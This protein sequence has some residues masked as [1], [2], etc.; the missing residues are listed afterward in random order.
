MKKNEA[1]RVKYLAYVMALP[2]VLLFSCSGKEETRGDEEE[3]AVQEVHQ[4]SRRKIDPSAIVLPAGMKIEAVAE[5]LSYPVDVT[6]DDKGNTYIAEAGGHTYGTKPDRAPEARIL[7]LLPD[8]TT[9]VLYD[10]VVP[11]NIIKN[12]ASSED[13]EEGLIPPLTGVTYH[14][15][16]LYISHRSRYSTYDLESG[17]FETIINGLPSW[18]EF[19]N[20]KPIFKD[21]KMY[22]FLSTQGNTGVQEKHWVE[23][24]NDFN[25]PE[26]REIPGED[27]TLTGKNFWVPTDK[28][29]IVDADSLETGVYVKLGEKTKAGQV[30]KGQE[31]C[32]GAFFSC[33]LDGNNIKRIAWGLRSS[34][35][36]RFSPDGKLITTMNSANPMPPRGLYFD[37]EPVYE[38]V[39]G[40]WYGW[41]DFFSGIPITDE[42]FS[43][44]EKR[45]DFVLT[46]ETHRKLLK[47]KDK[48]RQPIALLPVHSAAQGMVFG[49]SAFG[50][51]EQD[52]LVA[53][54]G[55]IVPEF[56]GKEYHPKLPKGMPEEE[57]APTGVKYNWPG[58]K[59]QQV[60][61]KTG[62]AKDFIYNKNSLP[63]SVKNTGGLERPLQME[64]GKDGALY[65]VDFGVVEFDDTGMNAMPFT[66]VLWKV[67]KGE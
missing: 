52:I 65:I 45:W 50:V 28:M 38:I 36:Y 8:G 16:K 55:T 61:L 46:E 32:N 29:T 47:G 64:W 12:K 39:Q 2:A 1:S 60:N 10:K 62:E 11:M 20:A 58:F 59:V 17:E 5:G 53:E 3:E 14:D 54:F 26:A 4:E 23:V 40:E 25:K 9:K 66:G 30:I 56:K 19:L 48:P 31:V 42:R 67:S 34:F 27:V 35:G 44:K 57:N 22:F 33:D 13:M 21:G 15:G 49:N 37:Y 43:G 24:I 7:Q 6:F 51:P 18:G 63:S 41:P